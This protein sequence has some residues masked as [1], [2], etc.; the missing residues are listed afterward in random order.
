MIGHVR[1]LD[2]LLA[3][4][5]CGPRAASVASDRSDRHGFGLAQ[6]ARQRSD[7]ALDVAR[8]HG[9]EQRV[10]LVAPAL[11]PRVGRQVRA[12]QAGDRGAQHRDHLQRLG[13]A[14]RRVEHLVERGVGGQPQAGVVLGVELGLQRVRAG[15][16][17][18]ACAAGSHGAAR[19]TRAARAGRTPRARRRPSGVATNAP[20]FGSTTTS[21]SACSLLSASRTG[22]RLT[23]NSAARSSCRSAAPGDQRPWCSAARSAAATESAVVRAPWLFMCSS[24]HVSKTAEA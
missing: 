21:P 10:V 9:L 5:G 1:S 20:R 14:R 15:A 24:I 17:C 13:A 4:S 2:R 7:R 16:A 22:M 8:G 19:R 6:V 18:A 11:A 23:P 3:F 12:V